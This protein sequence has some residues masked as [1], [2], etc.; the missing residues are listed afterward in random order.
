VKVKLKVPFVA[1]GPESHDAGSPL[2][3]VEVCITESLLI[4]ST[5]VPAVIVTLAGENAKPLIVMITVLGV[6]VG[7]GVGVGRGV[8]VGVGR[9][10][11]VGVGRG[12]GR[13]VGVGRRI[14]VAVGLGRAVAV[15]RGATAV[16][17]AVA[18]DVAMSVSVGVVVARA[19]RPVVVPLVPLQ[20]AS[21]ASRASNR[22][23]SQGR[24]RRQVRSRAFMV[25]PF[26]ICRRRPHSK[27]L[28]WVYARMLHEEGPSAFSTLRDE[29]ERNMSSGSECW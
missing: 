13:G 29:H 21:N 24:S 23:T 25:V 17:V 20:A 18:C 7:E 10:V 6:G 14:G 2:L 8:G 26:H 15:G 28:E 16:F 3:L 19:V 11:G 27:R 1:S 22:L 9:G 5:V 4:H 12:V